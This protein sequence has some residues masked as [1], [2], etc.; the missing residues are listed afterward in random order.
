MTSQEECAQQAPELKKRER[1]EYLDA[2]VLTEDGK[3]VVLNR[4][5]EALKECAESRD[6]ASVGFIGRLC[7]HI[8]KHAP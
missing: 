1:R 3:T 8:T 4:L 6:Y 2:S 7:E 5:Y